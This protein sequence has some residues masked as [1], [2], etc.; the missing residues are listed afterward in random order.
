M[1][2][3]PLHLHLLLFFLAW[4]LLLLLQ[5]VSSLQFRREDF[6]DGFAFG[7]GT[8]A[9]QVIRVWLYVQERWFWISLNFL[10][11]FW[12][13]MERLALATSHL[14]FAS[15][16]IQ[17]TY[18]RGQG[19][20]CVSEYWFLVLDFAVWGRSCWGWEDTEHLGYLHTFRSLS[21]S[22]SISEFVLDNFQHTDNA[23]LLC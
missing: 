10:P 7:A 1:E 18:E 21:I 23:A 3:R 6:P 9:Y 16:L 22:I 15:W 12:I 8:A 2:R 20:T 4:L 19:L 11:W 13:S 17:R 5:G 14:L